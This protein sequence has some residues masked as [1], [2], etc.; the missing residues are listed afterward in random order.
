MNE[1]INEFVAK[2]RKQATSYI[3]D[4]GE[5]F[6]LDLFHEKFAELIIRE[7]SITV[8]EN[9]HECRTTVRMDRILREHFR[10]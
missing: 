9:F 1:L 2:A 7:C 5:Q 4:G 3:K 6:D 8:S 10:R